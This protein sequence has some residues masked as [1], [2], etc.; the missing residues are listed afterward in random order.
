MVKKAKRMIS[1]LLAMITAVNMS[2]FIQVENVSASSE[3]LRSTFEGN[4]DGWTARGNATVEYTD[5][6]AYEGGYSLY[7]SGRTASWNGI[8]LGADFKEIKL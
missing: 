4:N 2:C 6:T 3:L 5:K 1:G 8:G 7:V